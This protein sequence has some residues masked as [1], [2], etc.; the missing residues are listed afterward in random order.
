MKKLSITILALALISQACKRDDAALSSLSSEIAV[1][2][3]SN[4]SDPNSV[5]WAGHYTNGLSVFKGLE[6]QRG[7]DNVYTS[8]S[9]S[10]NGSFFQQETDLLEETIWHVRKAPDDR[11]VEARGA[12]GL[13]VTRGQTY[14]VGFKFKLGQIPTSGGGNYHTIFQW[15][16][17]GTPMLQN[18]PLDLTYSSGKIALDYR[19][20]TTGYPTL[21]LF[22]SAAVDTTTWYS[23][24]IKIKTEDDLTGNTQIW[25][26]G[27]QNPETLLTGGNSYDGKTF[28]GSSIEPKWGY[29]NGNTN[30]GHIR[31][32]QLKIGATYESVRPLDPAQEVKVYR[33]CNYQKSVILAPGS[34]TTNNLQVLGMTNDNIS[35]IKVP[36][37]RS[38]TLYQNDNFSGDSITFTNN[39]SCLTTDSWNDKASSLRVK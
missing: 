38:I 28:D 14:Y 1:A 3:V 16:A 34:Y 29:Y 23:V 31:F 6:I 24:V 8:T 21:R 4:T 27:N 19:Q 22:E 32:S 12:N 26:N 37:G 9:P 11:R 5:I 2:T 30:D 20:P 7:S 36:T 35:S 10:A 25:W 18:I 13:T 33:D 15:K 39:R 17:Y